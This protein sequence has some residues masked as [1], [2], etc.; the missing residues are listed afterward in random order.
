MIEHDAPGGQRLPAVFDR[1]V[2]AE[3]LCAG[4]APR[5][6]RVGERD[7]LGFFGI[8]GGDGCASAGI[9]QRGA[10]LQ[11]QHPD[12]SPPSFDQQRR[13][14]RRRLRQH[15]SDGNDIAGNDRCW[16]LDPIDIAMDLIDVEQRE[17]EAAEAP[18]QELC[19]HDEAEPTMGGIC[20]AVH[21]SGSR[22]ARRRRTSSGATSSQGRTASTAPQPKPRGSDSPS[23]SP[24]PSPTPS[25][26]M[27][28]H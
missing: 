2:V 8:D 14:R 25:M 9:K 26:T 11:R 3:E 10:T 7:A 18:R 27:S 24:S 1:R 16:T 28:A 19:T 4:D 15:G 17:H 20:V 23:P 6:A 12:Q 5:V 21:V 22:S 13:G